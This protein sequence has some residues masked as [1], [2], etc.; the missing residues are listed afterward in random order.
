MPAAVA[1]PLIA[2]GASTGAQ[3]FGAH[4]AA[5][6]AKDAA[7]LQSQSADRA[8]AMMHQAY[9]PYLTAGGQGMNT[10]ARLMTPGVPYNPMLQQQDAA[11]YWPTQGAPTMAVPRTQSPLGRVMTR[12]RM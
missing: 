11:Q 9:Q 2:A 8:M 10:L 6:A 12:G 1:V 5:G 3:L 7:R 4:K